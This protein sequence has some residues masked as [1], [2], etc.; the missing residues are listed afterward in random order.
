MSANRFD[1]PVSA[2][3]PT[4]DDV[5]SD[6]ASLKSDVAGLVASIAHGG[7]ATAM[8]GV[9]R[10]TDSISS[11]AQRSKEGV[12]EAHSK[13][14]SCVSKRPLTSLLVAVGVG[15]IAARLLARR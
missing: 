5:K 10:L 4:L 6:L 9:E 14:S 13:L 3:A 8:E 12:A 1:S 7:K 15:A 11:A 2:T